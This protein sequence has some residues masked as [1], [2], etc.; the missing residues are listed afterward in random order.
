MKGQVKESSGDSVVTISPYTLPESNN[1]KLLSLLKPSPL[2]AST[3]TQE[4]DNNDITNKNIQL[5]IAIP[6]LKSIDVSHLVK[7]NNNIILSQKSEQSTHNG[8]NKTNN[9]VVD[10]LIDEN[11]EP[12]Y[13]ININELNPTNLKDQIS[14]IIIKNFPNFKRMSIEK[15]LY[16]L[17][18]LDQKRVFKWSVVNYEHV[19]KKIVF[20]RFDHLIDLKWFLMTYKD[21]ISTLFEN[22]KVEIITDEKLSQYF[23]QIDDNEKIQPS[24]I[25][26][27]TKARIQIMLQNPKHLEK[28]KKTG[29]ED[30]DE[31]L[32]YYSNY[33][34]DNSE[35]IDVPTHMRE[36]IVKDVIKFRSRVLLKEKEKRKREIEMER[37]K[38]KNKLKEL[39][40]GIKETNELEKNTATPEP[41]SSSAR[42]K[43]E[44]TRD[45]YEEMN[46]DEYLEYKELEEADKLEKQ[47][48]EEL[49]KMKNRERIERYQLL[50]R[51]ESL[52]KYES[53]LI[54]NKLKFID[55]F[56]N[57]DKDSTG[58]STSQLGALVNLYTYN[59]NSYLKTRIQKRNFEQT[60][61]EQDEK[62]EQ[63][64]LQTSQSVD[65]FVV[66]QLVTKK[67][68]KD[69][70]DIII[71]DLS[72]Q[73][74]QQLQSKIVDLVQE[75]LGVEDDVLVDVINENLQN[76]ISNGRK[77][78][79]Q[80]LSEVLDEDAENLVNDLWE[81]VHTL[82]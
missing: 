1:S 80:E 23:D 10:D 61:D 63:Q 55:E 16:S 17:I 54:D 2:I 14:I 12:K 53:N 70:S 37:I 58:K 81:Y 30:L 27:S 72:K 76:M 6:V 78:L 7:L 31:V 39:F 29:T 35:L 73:V 65:Q 44:S 68:K 34:V 5:D 71:N 13:F 36:S 11:E 24:K 41:E 21:T 4:N 50:D 49:I 62:Q 32:A 47:Y 22:D 75:Y 64:E 77:E 51:L 66:S 59:Y 79:I 52:E 60:K 19:D 26:E 15:L 8:S 28:S 45:E 33:K 69:T 38:T 20:I 40:E 25:P 42:P 3:T 57:I 74:K 48:Q 67:P 56:R 18:N 82:V 46:D 9:S 43:I